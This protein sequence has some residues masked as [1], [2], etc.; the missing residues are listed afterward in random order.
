MPYSLS[1]S[2]AVLFEAIVVLA[3]KTASVSAHAIAHSIM[4]K[5]MPLLAIDIPTPTSM[6]ANAPH[7][8]IPADIA[9]NESGCSVAIR[10]EGRAT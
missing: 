10:T 8:N 6:F 2:F 7:V 5:A 9:S 3:N 4:S 1:H